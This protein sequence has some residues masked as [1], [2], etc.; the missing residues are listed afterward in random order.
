[1]AHASW[2]LR[3]AACCLQVLKF[4]GRNFVNRPTLAAKAKEE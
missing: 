1:V 3:L 4:I 2:P